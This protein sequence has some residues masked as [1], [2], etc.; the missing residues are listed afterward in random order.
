MSSGT[1]RV[2]SSSLPLVQLGFG[3]G[4]HRGLH[5]LVGVG[6]RRGDDARGEGPLDERRVHEPDPLPLLRGEHLEDRL[7]GED[8]AAEVHEYENLVGVEALYRLPDPIRVRPEAPLGVAADR[9]ELDLA[10]HLPHELGRAIGNLGAVRD[11]HEPYHQELSRA[12]A[13]ASG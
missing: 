7:R 11:E 12:L 8:G 1:W 5:T 4:L 10:R 3:A 2:M 6:P 13:A 9:R